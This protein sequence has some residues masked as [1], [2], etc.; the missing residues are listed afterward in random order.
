MK[1]QCKICGRILPRR[2][3]AKVQAR[4]FWEEMILKT[5]LDCY[6]GVKG[7]SSYDQLR[8]RYGIVK[9]VEYIL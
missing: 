9:H 3:F 6:A 1:V 8:D 4:F 7:I 2:K 5:C